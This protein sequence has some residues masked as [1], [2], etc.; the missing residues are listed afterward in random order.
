[1]KIGKLFWP[2]VLILLF[3]SA[4][5]YLPWVGSLGYAKD[6]WYL[7]YDARSQGIGF[8]QEIYRI[9]RPARAYVMQFFY[10]LFGD[11]VLF[12]HL[13]AY[14][15]RVVAS[16]AFFWALLKIWP[17]KV[18]AGFVA[19]LLFLLY[20]GFLSQ[21]NP[22]DYQSQLLSLCLACLSIACT[23]QAVHTQTITSRLVYTALAILCGWAYL[24]LVEYFIGFEALRLILLVQALLNQNQK[25]LKAWLVA[26]LPFLTIP[27]VFLV[28][29][30]FFFQAER[31]AT[32]VSAQLGQLFS[33]PLTGFGW[34]LALLKDTFKAI[35]LAWTV[36]VYNL[37]FDL[38]LRDL[39]TGLGISTLAVALAL[40]ALWW[41]ARQPQPAEPVEKD[42]RT[43]FLL[44]G[45]GVV[46]AGLLPVILVNRQADFADYSRYLLASAPGAAMLV[47]ALID[48]LGTRF[49]RTAFLTL[50]ILSATL[51]HFANAA[52]A[53]LETRN[54]LDFWWQVSWRVPDLEPGT[55]LIAE[56]PLG[57]IQE[58]YFVWGPANLIYQAEKQNQTPINIQLPAAVLTDEVVLQILRGKGSETQLRRGNNVVRD[59]GNVLVLAQASPSSCV[60]VLDGNLPELSEKDQQRILLI[61]PHSKIANVL[62]NAEPQTPPASIFGAEPAHGWC[63]YYQQ[64][65]LARQLGDWKQVAAFGEKALAAGFYPNDKIEWLPF[66]QAYAALGQPE[67]LRRYVSI[68]GESPFIQQQACRLLQASAANPETV[69]YV[70]ESFC[71]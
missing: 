55:T 62:A 39:L 69:A 50:L 20:P 64:A 19:A 63:Y 58:D 6:D 52:Q 13:S 21:I 24:P 59:F 56:Y 36:P 15:Y 7:I 38:R 54:R 23:V 2:L 45:L 11:R 49:L 5:A 48:Q 37:A 70:Q 17:R 33:S 4:L 29:R 53:A 35:F 47:T 16:A 30:L 9:D 1:M 32:D 67:K 68:L 25:T 26:A 46:L 60:R 22:I 28:W 10:S 40:G 57:A 61:A 8:F 41:L 51:T 14:L 12:Y 43:Q 3:I 31:R 71:K 27:L 18:A 65:A 66:L 34:F 42:W 44:A